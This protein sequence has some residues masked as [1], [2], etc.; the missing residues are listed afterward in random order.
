MLKATHLRDAS[1]SYCLGWPILC[2]VVLPWDLLVLYTCTE[3]EVGWAV[4]WVGEVEFTHCLFLSRSWSSWNQQCLPIQVNN[5]VY[6][7]NDCHECMY[8][9]DVKVHVLR[10]HKWKCY[11]YIHVYCIW[12]HIMSPSMCICAFFCC[13]MG[14]A[15]AQLY[16]TSTMEHHHFDHSLMILNSQV[17]N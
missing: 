17:R 12:L 5:A 16:S 11:A 15:L 7:H 3:W 2:C 14:S 8:C 13:R 6:T 9:I 1:F 10:M 4:D